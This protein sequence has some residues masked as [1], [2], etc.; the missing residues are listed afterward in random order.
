MEKF[1]SVFFEVC[2]EKYF[3]AG[4]AFLAYL[5]LCFPCLYDTDIEGY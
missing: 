1:N 3:S 2:A 5:A 4:G